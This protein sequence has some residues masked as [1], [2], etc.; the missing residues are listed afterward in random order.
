MW[1]PDIGPPLRLKVRVVGLSTLEV[2]AGGLV[3]RS[4]QHS[5]HPPLPRLMGRRMV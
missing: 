1:L 5:T 2:G 4:L 3:L